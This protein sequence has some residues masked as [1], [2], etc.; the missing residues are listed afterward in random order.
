MALGETLD[1]LWNFGN[2]NQQ[3]KNRFNQM[4]NKIPAKIMYLH[5]FANSVLPTNGIYFRNINFIAVFFKL[6]DNVGV[7][8]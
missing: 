7:F 2:K 4:G 5:T 8:I 6:P 3:K 1:L